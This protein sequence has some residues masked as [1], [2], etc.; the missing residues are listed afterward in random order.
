MEE[1]PNHHLASKKTHASAESSARNKII[2]NKYRAS[3]RRKGKK[4]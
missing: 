2:S 4:C 1:E 3:E